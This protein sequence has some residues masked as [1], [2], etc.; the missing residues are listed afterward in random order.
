MSISI[1]HDRFSQI[2]EINT[3]ITPQFVNQLVEY[4][5]MFETKNEHSL[6]L[7]SYL[8]GV[9]PI[10][11]TN[12]EN[13][14]FFSL[15]HLDC[16]KIKEI[17]KD[18]PLIDPSWTVVN[19]PYNY[20]VIFTAYRVITSSLKEEL[21]DR[22]L[23]ILFKMLQ[24]KFFTS[25]V[26]HY[27]KFGADKEVM[28]ATIKELT[29]RYD[30]VKYGTWKEVIE[31]RARDIYSLESIHRKT[32]ETFKDDQAIVYV[33]SDIQSRIRQKVKLVTQE[34]YKNKDWNN[35]IRSYNL[36]DEVD[37]EKVITA[38]TN[39]LDNMITQMLQ[40]IQTPTRFVDEELI[41]ALSNKFSAINQDMFRRILYTFTENAQLQFDSGDSKKT[42][43]NRKDENSLIYIGVELLVTELIQKTYRFCILT[44]TNMK[45]KGDILTKTMNLYSSSRMSDDDILTI[46]RSVVYFVTK[47]GESVRPATI[48][49][50]S[51]AFILYII[52]KSMQYL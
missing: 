33:L 26:Q 25:L 35:E 21:K 24:Y 32:L 38:T 9:Y 47:T 13:S 29:A 16:E 30:I 14:L 42:M 34:Y 50:M 40:Q 52:I 49:S 51:I 17:L 6:A 2:P 10:Y 12:V 39:T 36:V 18:H 11:F 45:S 19:D 46:K 3:P 8:L 5:A 44:K 1:L 41:T 15:L 7:N 48:A 28:D 4:C 22:A 23:L 20:T 37:G 27:Y 43:R 31:V